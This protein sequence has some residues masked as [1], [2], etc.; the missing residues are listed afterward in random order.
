MAQVTAEQLF[1]KIKHQAGRIAELEL[2]NEAQAIE[3][4]ALKAREVKDEAE[5]REV[6]DVATDIARKGKSPA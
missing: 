3:I 4:G 1:A 5:A 6:K 2:I